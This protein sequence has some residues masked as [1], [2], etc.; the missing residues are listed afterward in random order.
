MRLSRQRISEFLILIIVF[1]VVFFA[2]NF[3]T[4]LKFNFFV[5]NIEINT[6]SEINIDNQSK[7][8][9]YNYRDDIVIATPEQISLYK[10]DGTKIKQ[11]QLFGDQITVKILGDTI[12]VVET[13]RGDMALLAGKDLKYLTEKKDIG[14]IR[15]V[16]TTESG[17]IILSM[18]REKRFLIFDQNLNKIAEFH[19]PAG[20]LTSL[21][22]SNDG[23]RL[24]AAAIDIENGEFKSYVYQ[25]DLNGK[26]IGVSDLAGDLIFSVYMNENQI[27]VTDDKLKSYDKESEKLAEEL[28]LSK[29]DRSL[30]YKNFL[31]TAF[32]TVDENGTEQATMAIYNDDFTY[33]HTGSL[34]ALPE[35]IVVNDKFIITYAEGVIY[36]Y[37]HALNSLAFKRTNRNLKGLFCLSDDKIV[38]YDNSLISVFQIE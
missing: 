17:Y 30:M 27:I 36:F 21:N 22:L 28:N 13:L 6:L 3:L 33:K 24:L 2:P 15:E 19:L 34:S 29:I 38:T 37:D 14:S 23:K 16:L 32:V 26:T 12:L 35:E 25:Y 1:I 8:S 18:E 10:T 20:E 11:R 7:F 31:Y 9:V 4:W 5:Q